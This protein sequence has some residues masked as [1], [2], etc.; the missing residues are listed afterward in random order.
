VNKP[1]N[2]DRNREVASRSQLI[3]L[4]VWDDAQVQQVM[5]GELGILA[6]AKP[7]SIIWS[8]PPFTLPQFVI[9]QER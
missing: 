5:T 8:I 4:A 3:G 6:G 9:L 7:G 2:F 1:K